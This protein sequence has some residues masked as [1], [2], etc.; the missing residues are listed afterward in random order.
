MKAWLN[1]FEQNCTHRHSIPWKEQLDVAP[2]LVQ[3]L[4]RSLQRFQVGESGEGRHLR[5]AANATGDRDYI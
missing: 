1:H 3:P 4:I 5:A 2:S